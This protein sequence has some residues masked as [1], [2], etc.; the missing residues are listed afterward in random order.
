MGCIFKGCASQKF[1]LAM[2]DIISENEGV[3]SRIHT[4]VVQLRSVISA[5]IFT[6]TVLQKQLYATSLADHLRTK[7]SFDIKK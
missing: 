1:H 4:I 6:T 3:V 5:A 2:S 7:C